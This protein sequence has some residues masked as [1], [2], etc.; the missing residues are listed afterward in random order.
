MLPPD[1][2]ITST[3]K[4]GVVYKLEAPE[5]INT[6]TPHY[7]IVVAVEDSNN[8]LC[9]CTTQLQKKIA[10][11]THTGGDLNT[12]AYLEPNSENGLTEK[13]YV[14]CN[15]YY[16]VSKDDLI[17]KVEQGKLN[18]K[19]MLSKEEYQKIKD[20]INLSETNDIPKYLLIYSQ[21]Q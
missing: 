14:N 12:I 10:H 13:T 5:L 6:K 2:Y 20:S 7:F 17:N 15:D 1:Y 4:V 16:E 8:Y 21:D 9:I 3:L 19:G 11:I 18:Y